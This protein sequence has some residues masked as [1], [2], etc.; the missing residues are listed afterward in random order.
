MPKV[1]NCPRI[2]LP[3]SSATLP[4]PPPLIPSSTVLVKSVPSA[5]PPVPISSLIA[6]VVPSAPPSSSPPPSK[7]P[8]PP[9]IR[10]Q[11]GRKFFSLSQPRSYTKIPDG[12]SLIVAGFRKPLPHETVKSKH[13]ILD[14]FGGTWSAPHVFNIWHKE[15]ESGALSSDELTTH[16]VALVRNSAEFFLAFSDRKSQ[17][18]NVLHQIQQDPIS[19]DDAFPNADTKDERKKCDPDFLPDEED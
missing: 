3:A 9:F 13:I 5:P 12:C 18:N 17:I 6:N 19:D 1:K 10:G 11:V 15:I 14:P 8:C 4:L 7:K 2:A 16:R